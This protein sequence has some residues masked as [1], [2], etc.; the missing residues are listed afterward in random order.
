ME[1]TRPKSIPKK[2]FVLISAKTSNPFE[3]LLAKTWVT[4][5]TV[6]IKNISNSKENNP[7]VEVIMKNQKD[8]PAVTASDLNLGDDEFILYR[9]NKGNQAWLCK[10]CY[11][12]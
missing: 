7:V 12:N 9:I 6:K 10:S 2:I 11:S 4:V 8:N 3:I 1:I 5:K